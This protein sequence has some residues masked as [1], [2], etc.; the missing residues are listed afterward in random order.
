M[1]VIIVQ[2]IKEPYVLNI[3]PSLESMQRIVG[4]YIQAIY[5]FED[6]GIALVCNEEGKIYDLTPN[7]YLFNEYGEPVELIVGNF[8]ICSAPFESENFEDIPEKLIEKYI[9]YFSFKELL[10]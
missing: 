3:N 6:E 5:P 8:F 10:K 4:G 7:R 2:P 9:K 1:K